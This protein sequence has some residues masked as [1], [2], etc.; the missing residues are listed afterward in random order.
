DSGGYHVGDYEGLVA[1]GNTFLSVWSMPHGSDPTSIFFRGTL[2]GAALEAASGGHNH[3]S[4]PL[5]SPQVESLLPEAI[6]RWQAAGAD[7]AALAGIEVR[8]ADLG[9]T[10][11]GL[12]SGHTIWLDDNAA[13][14]GWFVDPTP[15]DDREFTTPGDQGQQNRI[16]LLTVL[17][18]EVGH[19][20]GHE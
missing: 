11:L 12:A 8:I 15:H 3:A 16:D 1:A 10:T 19:L 7:P 5:T 4:A 13:G 17:M 2:A 9:G 6:C 14:W 20:L 18:H